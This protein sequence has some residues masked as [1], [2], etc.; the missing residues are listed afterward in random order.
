MAA[1]QMTTRVTRQRV[2]AE[3]DGVHEQDECAETHTEL[4][5][6]VERFDGVPQEDQWEWQRKVEEVA[7]RILEDQRK[8]RLAPIARH[9]VG[10]C[11]RGRRPHERPV[12]GL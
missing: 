5:A 2:R 8:P 12:V 9:L 10:Y 3:Q 6:E 1:A 11:A 4:A 7:V